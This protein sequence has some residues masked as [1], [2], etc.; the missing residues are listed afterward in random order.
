MTVPDRLERTSPRVVLAFAALIAASLQAV[1]LVAPAIGMGPIYILLIGLIA[2]RLDHRTT[3]IAAVAIILLSMRS[4]INSGL[5]TTTFIAM[6]RI[7]IRCGVFTFV[8]ITMWALRCAYDRER[9]SARLDGMTGLLNKSSFEAAMAE[10]LSAGTTPILVGVM[11]LDDFKSIN[12]RH[13]H[14]AGDDTIKTAAYAAVRAVGDQGVVGRMGGDEFAFVVHLPAA[15]SFDA[16][17]TALHRDISQALAAMSSPT[18]I[19]MGCVMAPP[20]YSGKSDA[21]ILRADALLYT[22]KR[23]G[24]ASVVVA[25]IPEQVTAHAVRATPALWRNPTL[26][27]AQ[28]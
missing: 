21:L 7:G 28:A 1:D 6:L 2:W 18:T 14:A 25:D 13:G 19:S 17:A 10:M 12:D 8:V 20:N 27:T 24:K 26:A 16:F 9:A 4:S 5:P 22:A 11:D 3:V 23:T 15:G